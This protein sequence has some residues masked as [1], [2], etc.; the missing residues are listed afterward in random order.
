MFYLKIKLF[1]FFFLFIYSSVF[2]LLIRN[3]YIFK[4]INRLLTWYISNL[5]ISVSFKCINVPKNYIQDEK[6]DGNINCM[7]LRYRYNLFKIH[8]WLFKCVLQ[9]FFALWRERQL[10]L[11]YV[12]I[13]PELKNRFVLKD[14][15]LIYWS[16]RSK[17]SLQDFWDEV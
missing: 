11:F 9:A 14:V 2:Q 13:L 15:D 3:K 1:M 5:S 17:N 10:F 6:Y 12:Q 8:V 4:Q 7:H 16:T